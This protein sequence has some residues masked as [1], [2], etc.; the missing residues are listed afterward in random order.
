[1]PTIDERSHYGMAKTILGPSWVGDTEDAYITMW[2]L[3]WVRVAEYDDTV[4]AEKYINGEP[5]KWIDLPRAQR[6][7]LEDRKLEGK[8]VMWN[9]A[10]FEST[11]EGK[12][13]VYKERPGESLG[14]LFYLSV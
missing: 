2:L 12:Q 14:A 5:V 13:V 10:V 6:E 9:D 7:W 3:G 11:R 1:M 8:Q 4:Y